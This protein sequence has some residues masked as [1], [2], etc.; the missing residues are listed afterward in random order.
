M[1]SS[2]QSIPYTCVNMIIY[3]MY[4]TVVLFEI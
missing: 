4:V 1:Y 3:L 2:I